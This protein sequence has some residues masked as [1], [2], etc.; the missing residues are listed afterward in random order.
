MINIDDGRIVDMIYSRESAD[1]AEWLKTYPN[2]HVVSRDGSMTYSNAINIAHPDAIQVSDRFHLI[3]GLTEA[4]GQY[5]RGVVPARI[6]VETESE[7]QSEGYWGKPARKRV[8][9]R[10]QS[11]YDSVERK[12]KAIQRVRDLAAQG[13]NPSAIAR[14][15][16]HDYKTV[17]K[18]LDDNSAAESKGYGS[19]FASK[20]KPYTNII[21]DMLQ[22]GKK[23]REIELVIRALGYKGTQSTIRMYAAKK[24]KL[25]QAAYNGSIV[26]TEV[27]ERRWLIKLLYSSIENVKGITEG[28][29]EKVLI[30]YPMIRTVYHIVREFKEIIFSK[31]V[32]ELG[33]WIE[34]AKSVG[35]DEIISFLN[36]L[37]R[38][39]EAVKNAIRYD[40]SNGIAEGNI[41]KIKLYKRVMYGRCG[42]ETLRSK[43]LLLE[44]R[45]YAN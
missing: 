14:E 42:F 16:G 12:T 41:N 25:D 2:I 24:R 34:Q 22:M 3:H 40:Y 44:Q 27:I 39:I 20:L 45:K 26:N 11:H 18:Y 13:L 8:S 31:R 6:R 28:Q 10:E 29:I 43:T 32:A 33:D 35:S 21:D 36:G 1:V 37:L 38:D 15:T 30:S 7:G 4:A 5:I 9:F 17:K 19:S 23:F